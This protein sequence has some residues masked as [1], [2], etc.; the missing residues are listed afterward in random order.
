MKKIMALCAAFVIFVALVIGNVSSAPSE[1]ALKE[2]YRAAPVYVY[3]DRA[4]SKSPQYLASAIES[5]IEEGENVRILLGSSELALIEPCSSHP[6]NFFRNNNY[7]MTT[8]AIGN[9][10]FQSLW[11]AIEIGALDSLGAVPGEKVAI[12]VSMQW[13]MGEGCTPEAFLNSFSW[14]AYEL[15]MAN[16]SISDHTK[17]AISS[18]VVA[19]G[20]D[21]SKVYGS[22]EGSNVSQRI[23]YLFGRLFERGK[24]RQEALEA[25]GDNIPGGGDCV[26]LDREIPDWN[27]WI[28]IAESEGK[29]V[30]TNNDLG[31]YDDYYSRH[32]SS[33]A[34]KT[35]L[36]VPNAETPFL[37]W[38]N[39]ELGDLR[40]F[41]QVCE[42]IQVEPLVI[43]MPVKSAY[44]DYTE[45]NNESRQAYYDIIRETCDGYG[46]EYV[47]LSS[48]EE[49]KYFMM[50]IMH[51][52]WTAWVHVNF[53]MMEFFLG[54]TVK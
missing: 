5:R 4:E 42:E 47:D 46:V 51:F 54:S 11:D 21:E 7:G 3:A 30:C 8:I 52:G 27:E 14:D 39:A 1:E 13:F 41:L 22:V 17:S 43:I 2:G 35:D 29:S 38:E 33:W 49:D 16:D 44:Y 19:L 12:I 25:L 32:V 50:D 6:A 34:E 15:C 28:A 9:A 36:S 23:D 18:R 31:I 53:S 20:V 10:G 48:Y 45:Y 37:G 40:L 26:T 24:E